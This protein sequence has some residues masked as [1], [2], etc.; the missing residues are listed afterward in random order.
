MHVADGPILFAGTKIH[1]MTKTL[2]THG[3][4]TI[5]TLNAYLHLLQLQ[6]ALQ[7]MFLGQLHSSHGWCYVLPFCI[8]MV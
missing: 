6:S 4:A 3:L 7:L 2:L 8:L 1:A 5:L